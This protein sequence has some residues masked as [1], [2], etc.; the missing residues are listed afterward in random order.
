MPAERDAAP[1]EDLGAVPV[2]GRAG[3]VTHAARRRPCA[4]RRP[5]L[6]CPWRPR[7]CWLLW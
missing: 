2:V 4:G 5:R 3:I 7:A 6:R 1:R